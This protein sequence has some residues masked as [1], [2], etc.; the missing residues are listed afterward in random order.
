[1]YGDIAAGVSKQINVM[2]SSFEIKQE[3][4]EMVIRISMDKIVGDFLSQEEQVQEM[5]N[6]M[7]CE[8][9]KRVKKSYDT[10]GGSIEVEGK[11]YTSK[12]CEKKK[13]ETLF[14]EVA[15]CREVYQSHAGGVT[16]I[17]MDAGIGFYGSSS[18]LLCKVV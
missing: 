14:G 10:D 18:P 17:P 4:S 16:Y 13:Y 11:V 6:S 9:V 3:G 12:G 15:V 2:S 5:L 1:M 8:M 7:G